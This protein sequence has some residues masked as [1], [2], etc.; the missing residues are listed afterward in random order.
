MPEDTPDQLQLPTDEPSLDSDL[1]VSVGRHLANRNT[2]R[3]FRRSGSR[4]SVEVLGEPRTQHS[5][6]HEEEEVD[7][8]W[9][10][11]KEEEAGRI[12]M[13]VGRVPRRAGSMLKKHLLGPRR[14]KT[15]PT[16]IVEAVNSEGRLDEE[17][18]EGGAPF[19]A[20]P[21][22]STFSDGPLHASPSG[23][24]D[25]LVT[26]DLPFFGGT[27]LS[28]SI[29]SPQSPYGAP[30]GT[31]STLP[32]LS[33]I[34]TYES[35]SSSSPATSIRSPSP[36]ATPPRTLSVDGTLPKGHKRS[37]S[38]LSVKRRGHGSLRFPGRSKFLPKK[39][40]GAGKRDSRD[41]SGIGLDEAVTKA[42]KQ[43]GL[44]G[45]EQ[46]KVEVDVLYEHQRGL[47]VWGLPKFSSAA[48]LQVDPFEWC[49]ATLQPSPFT[50]HD[51]PCP[52]YWYWRDSE[53]MVDMSGDKDEEGWSYAVR[54][55]SRYWRGE[56]VFPY[57][58]V[59]RRRWIRTRIYRP[60]PV[61]PLSSSG[62]SLAATNG[63]KLKLAED[64]LG[65]EIEDVEDGCNTGR[66]V[67]GKAQD[68][69]VVDLRS[70]CR[71]LPLSPERRA[72]IFA[73]SSM[74]T[75]AAAATIKNDSCTV[76][77]ARNP[78]L[79]YRRL[80]L[81]ALSF[82]GDE[83]GG[84]ETPIWRD[85]VR[86]I[87]FRRVMNVLKAHARID[88][89]RV[90]I[91]KLWLGAEG[92]E[93]GR[94]KEGNGNGNGGGN[95][96]GS[97]ESVELRPEA[98]DVWDVIEARVRFAPAFASLPSPN[99]GLTGLC[100]QL[101]DLLRNFDYNLT[102]YQ[103]L[104]LI[105]SLH[106]IKTTYHHHA[107]YDASPLR[108]RAR[109]NAALMDRLAFYAE[110]EGMVKQYERGEAI[111]IEGEG[112]GGGAGGFY[113]QTTLPPSASAST[114]TAPSPS[115]KSPLKELVPL[116]PTS[117]PTSGSPLKGT[118]SLRD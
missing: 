28:S 51:Y 52:P 27:R 58:F 80:K 25:S 109:L 38:G 111:K 17:E 57:A 82:G 22:T 114:S 12:R 59:R 102:R 19:A 21:S 77:D 62:F 86:E 47:V 96:N 53:F 70:A 66:G 100:S 101:D 41:E 23:S 95:G 56:A 1:A 10:G 39:K 30:F 5:D 49:D 69:V 8:A 107:G 118:V 20:M 36:F 13:S 4:A 115:P 67:D 91:W 48:L 110:V 34:R 74:T 35:T 61:L 7:D 44:L 46:E 3:R 50:P 89:K 79:S 97:G 71:C 108:R 2:G 16:V 83:G 31:R 33:E 14:G 112:G 73:E 40:R 98:E 78:F 43:A 24:T 11:Y 106:P 54:F 60:Q 93:G 32:T 113:C 18:D 37:S 75:S 94:S 84:V 116:P 68:Q 85:A 15:L 65:R 64:V 76:V 103:F 104:Q 55:R 6:S 63:S 29:S 90:E 92:K 87:N 9:F 42:L 72:Q 105:L 26:L 45:D 81:E 88:R 99:A 117:P